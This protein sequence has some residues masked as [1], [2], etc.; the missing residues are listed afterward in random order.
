[1]AA[2]ALERARSFRESAQASAAAESETLRSAILD[3]LAH[4]FK[5]PLG[6]ILAAA[7]GL[8]ESGGL[9]PDQLEMTEL[10]ESE[11]SRLGRLAARLLRIED[12]RTPDFRP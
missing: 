3:A 10:I 8:R 6:A 9:R 4:E 12:R 7:G 5:T 2:T 11:S 1:M